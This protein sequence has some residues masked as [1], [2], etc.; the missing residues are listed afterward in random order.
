MSFAWTN[1]A[2]NIAGIDN[3]K[4][5]LAANSLFRPENRP[6]AIVAP[7]LEIPGAMAI[8]WATPITRAF[9]KDMSFTSLSPGLTLSAPHKSN[10]CDNQEDPNVEN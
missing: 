10:A 7:D 8:P 4:L 6:A 2:P 1:A 3:K 9:L 5:N